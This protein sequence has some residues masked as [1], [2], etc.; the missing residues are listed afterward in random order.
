[1]AK[2]HQ[3]IALEKGVKPQRYSE[4]SELHKLCQKPNLFSGFSKTYQKRDEESEDLPGESQKIQHVVAHVL[5]QARDGYQ[6]WWTITAR[7]EWANTQAKADV[8]VGAQTII[9]DVPVT[10]LLFLEKQLTDIRTFVDKLPTLDP[11]EDWTLD[12]STGHYKTPMV[13]T[14]RTKKV[15]RPIVLYDATPEHP[16]QTQLITEDVVA[17]YWQT[18]KQSAAMTMPA[19]QAM[20]SRVETLLRAVKEAREAANSHEEVPVPPIAEALLSYMFP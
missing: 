5:A 14:H 12:P 9:A 15:Q 10:F 11:I 20:A 19:K 16:A 6:D 2:L 1:M 7:K 4:V 17:G 3:L 8:V 18:I 13:S